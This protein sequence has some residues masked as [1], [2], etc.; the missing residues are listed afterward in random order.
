MG[1]SSHTVL[2]IRGGN[3]NSRVDEFHFI[4]LF[5]L[6]TYH[7]PFLSFRFFEKT[8]YLF[9]AGSSPHLSV[10]CLRTKS[11]DIF[12]FYF[13]TVTY[14]SLF[15]AFTHLTHLL[16]VIYHLSLSSWYHFDLDTI[17]RAAGGG[18]RAFLSFS[19]SFFFFF[20]TLQLSA[21]PGY[22]YW[23][24]VFICLNIM[25]NFAHEP[26]MKLSVSPI[27]YLPYSPFYSC[28]DSKM[29]FT[30]Q[31]N[32][33]GI[34]G[35][36][37]ANGVNTTSWRFC[38]VQLTEGCPSWAEFP[39]NHNTQ[40]YFLHFPMDYSQFRGILDFAD[41]QLGRVLLQ[42]AFVV[43][44]NGVSYILFVFNSRLGR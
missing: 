13:V 9:G 12:I 10:A 16:P 27:S 41:L 24:F 14:S 28:P 44:L 32:Q 8:T 11:Q 37:F 29:V 22:M 5:L 19:F 20:L 39:Q 21:D 25:Y 42:H 30:K 26:R 2:M 17:S 33:T 6:I 18:R 43:I 4:P 3:S 1:A 38:D 40:V 23:S 7:I 15:S 31:K 35:I 36:T 34:A